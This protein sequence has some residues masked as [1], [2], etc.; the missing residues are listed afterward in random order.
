MIDKVIQTIKMRDYT[1][2]YLL[3]HNYVKLNINHQQLIIL[4]YLIN[5]KDSLYNPKAISKDLNWSLKEVMETV[6]ELS[7]MVLIDIKVKKSKQG[8]EE[9]IDLSNI[10]NKL[11]LLVTENEK[12]SSNIYTVFEKE[13]GRTL[14]PIEYELIGSWI[15]GKYNEEVIILA[16]K[17]A[18]YNGVSNFRYIDKILYE[19]NRKGLKT[20]NDVQNDKQKFHK[21][22]IS[23][24]QIFEYDWLHDH[25]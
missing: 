1:V 11:A 3:F 22:K 15:D 16:L 17:E 20:K 12:S 2:P 6:Q 18:V 8:I 10:Y 5:A 4:I 14:S 9:V 23:E 25:E 7:N 24:K 21:Q 13:L 19:W